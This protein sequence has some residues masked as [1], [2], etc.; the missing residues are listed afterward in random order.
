M[1]S[2]PPRPL[3]EER[4]TRSPFADPKVTALSRLA[5]LLAPE[6]EIERV[7]VVGCGAGTE[8]AVLADQ[9]GAEV[10]GIDLEDD[11]DP[12][13]SERAD[14]RV[15]DATDLDFGD[16]RFDLIYSF[17]ALEHIA[18]PEA[19]LSEM[20]RVLAPGGLYCL[21][22]PN[23]H[24]LLGYFGSRTTLANKVRW[25]LQDLGMRLRGRFRNEHGAHAGFSSA[26]LR[27]LVEQA[28]GDAVEVTDDY[29]RNL[30]AA[31]RARP[32]ANGI[33]G[34][35]AAR[36]LFPCVYFAGRTPS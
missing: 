20:R 6:A 14:L 33:A 31:G 13:A 17:H 2:P 18:D 36:F 35:P 8:A 3:T 15:M 21:G 4:P 19:A 12:E 32:L 7:L 23:R 29:Y 26:E 16:H 10:V 30:Y 28:F 5:L 27:A 24:R 34:T 22:T 1:S 9:L 25:N 11:F